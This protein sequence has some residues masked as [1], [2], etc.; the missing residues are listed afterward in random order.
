MTT[1]LNDI[2]FALRQL[3]KSPGFTAIVVLTLALGISVSM[4]MW[5]LIE[6][7]MNPP[8]HFP[9]PNRI[10]HVFAEANRRTERLFS[11]LTYQ[12]LSEQLQPLADLAAMRRHRVVLKKEGWSCEYNGAH[13]SRNF[14][15]VAQVKAHLGYMFSEEDTQELK[16]RPSVVLS[17]RLWKSHFGSDPELIGRS[18]LFGGV[19]RVVLGIAPSWFRSDGDRETST[20]FW[21]PIHAWN[22]REKVLV[23]RMVGRLRPGVALRALRTETRAAFSRLDVR[24]PKTQTQ[25]K[26]RIVSDRH[27]RGLPWNPTERIL[28]L[29][30]TNSVLLIVCLN[31]SGL[32]L[33]RVDSRRREMAVRQALGGSRSRLIRQL[34]T[35]GMVL[36]T[37]ASG[38]SLLTAFCFMHLLRL[39][40]EFR[41]RV[42]GYSL[43]IT[44]GSTLLF[45]LLPIWY[46][47]TLDLIPALRVDRSR[48]SRLGRRLFGL[49]A[50]VAL[51]LALSVVLMVCAGHFLRYFFDFTSKGIG[52]TH[53][54]VLVAR[55]LGTGRD[56]DL[57][58]RDLMT[59]VRTQA[60]VEHAGLSLHLPTGGGD[61]KAY[62]VSLP[63]N[64]KRTDRRGETIQ[65]NIVDPGYFPA[66]GISILAGHNFPEQR[67][68]SDTRQVIVS[69]A[70]ASRYWPDQGPIGRFIRLE[71]SD[72]SVIPELAQVIGLVP[73]VTAHPDRSP[74]PTLYV[75]L[76][77]VTSHTMTL[78]VKT[79]GKPQ[80]LADPVRR[81]IQQFDNTMDVFAMTTLTDE[82][83][84]LWAEPMAFVLI[85]ESLS[86]VGL[87]LACVGLYGTIAFT[88]TRRTYELG[89]RLALGARGHDVTR[90]VMSQG[91]KLSLVGLGIGL[92][93]AAIIMRIFRSILYDIFSF[94]PYV[95]GIASVVILFAATLATYMPAR[96]AARIDPMEALRY[97]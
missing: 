56:T 26:P 74:D 88:V 61:R 5:V 16:Q 22:E 24:H 86:L 84:E 37:L 21:I 59:K 94:D 40:M 66:L 9:D 93:G 10:V 82:V 33:A 11:Y 15:S 42:V 65:A 90:T 50:M 89:I 29:A 57:F 4:A 70:F 14:F 47:C 38:V 17:H 58:F 68:P 83:N 36:A 41:V 77:Q 23:S 63:D 51:Q 35:E 67:G 45:E 53:R 97:E 46:T 72:D 79:Q 2:K 69:Q 87:S 62:R 12:D 95:Y 75:P 27:L 54:N 44:L 91:L 34:F 49:P 73:N 1:I 13:V 60:G 64:D 31:L 96:R 71:D 80:R 92:T 30:I 18:I 39:P 25:S 76:G 55:D 52:F 48:R 28:L 85:I 3:R 43:A 81:I 19:P 6:A 7:V 8:S 32:L 78:V 20:E